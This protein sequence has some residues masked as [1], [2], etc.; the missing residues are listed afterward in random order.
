MAPMML[1]YD[2]SFTEQQ[3]NAGWS[4]SKESTGIYVLQRTATTVVPMTNPNIVI[5]GIV[6]GSK[7][8][9][10]SSV[11]YSIQFIET[12]QGSFTNYT[13]A[14]GC[15]IFFHDQ[16]GNLVDPFRFS[17]FFTLVSGF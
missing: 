9:N 13:E 3:K 16:V 7:L 14:A 8:G 15:K 12:Y 2:S 10:G 6:M 11:N 17:A 5:G 1:T 4:I